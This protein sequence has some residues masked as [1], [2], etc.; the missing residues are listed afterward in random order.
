MYTDN[1]EKKK[2]TRSEKSS[3]SLFIDMSRL[4]SVICGIPKSKGT[5]INN[6]NFYFSARKFTCMLVDHD[7][8]Y[9]KLDEMSQCEKFFHCAM[10][11]T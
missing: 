11:Q 6:P 1:N 10:T 9:V 4:F 8:E 5:F 2:V 3:C 7:I